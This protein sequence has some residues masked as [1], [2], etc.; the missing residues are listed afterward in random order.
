M[1]R[2]AARIDANQPD[3]F[4]LWRR[5]GVLVTD[6]SGMGDGFPDA[7]LAYRGKL[8]LVEIKD[9]SKPPSAQRLT[10]AQEVFHGQH[11]AHGVEIPIVRT[12]ADALAVIGAR[13]AA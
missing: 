11:R 13:G 7:M 3:I 10:A 2:R 12:E 5:L 4:K 8:I 1:M 6:T 9:G